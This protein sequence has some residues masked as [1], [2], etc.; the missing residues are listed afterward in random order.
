MSNKR[1]GLKVGDTVASRYVIKGEIGEGGMGTVYKAMPFHDPSQNVA[2]KIIQKLRALG[3][4]DILRFQKEAA[5]MSL[6][7]HPNII[8]F[9]ELGLLNNEYI[10]SSRTGPKSSEID[11]GDG[12]YIVMEIADGK[13]LKNNLRTDSRKDLP[14]FFQVGLQVSSALDYTHGKNI[15]HRDIKPQ[16]IVVGKTW[17]E[18]KGIL[19][20]VLDFG[21]ARLAELT[22]SSASN[23]IRNPEVAGTP[24]YMAPEQTPLMR[25]APVDH[26]VDLYSLGCV[27]YEILTGRPPFV[28]SSREK[29]MARHVKA[30]PEPLRSIRPDVPDIID[31]IVMKLLAKHPDDRYQTAFGLHA[32]LQKA[33]MKLRQQRRVHVSFPLGKNDGFRAVSAQLKLVGRDH[34]FQELIVKYKS[35]SALQGR[36][37]MA[38]IKGE[39]GMGK[40]R[41]LTELRAYLVNGRIRFISTNFSRH[42]TNLPYNALANGFNE[43]LMRLLKGQPHEAEELR[44]KIRTVLGSMAYIVAE[45]IPGLRP[46]IDEEIKHESNV[47]NPEVDQQDLNRLQFQTFAAAF[48][49]FTRCLALDNQPIVFILDDLHWADEK[50]LAL[51]DQ[52]FSHN[53]LQRFYLVASYRP[54]ALK[55]SQRLTDFVNKFKR[56]KRRYI[57]IDLGTLQDD[58]ISELAANMLNSTHSIAPDLITFL[59]ART[60]GNPMYLVELIRTLVAQERINYNSTLGVWEYDINQLKNERIKLDSVDL[61][62]NRIQTY[63]EEDRSVLEVASIIGMTFQYELLL[64]GDNSKGVLARNA[65]QKAIDEGLIS[66]TTDDPDLKH[67]GKSYMFIHPRAREAILDTVVTNRKKQIHKKIALYLLRNVENTE[68]ENILFSIVHHLNEA[69]DQD[70]KI[71]I[72]IAKTGVRY[73]LSAGDRAT[74]KS[75]WAQARRYFEKAEVLVATFDPKRSSNEFINVA[76]RLADIECKLK[77]PQK[78][79]LIYESLLK[80][81]ISRARFA[82]VASKLNSITIYGGKIS[83]SLQMI[84]KGLYKLG[85]PI[86]SQIF[87]KSF[88]AVLRFLRDC[89]PSRNNKGR[90]YRLL[91]K[92]YQTGVDPSMTSEASPHFYGMELYRQAQVIFL[93]ENP[94]IA[95]FYHDQTLQESIRHIASPDTILRSVADRTFLM[96]YFGLARKSYSLIDIALDIARALNLE[97]TQGYIQLYRVLTLDHYRGKYEDFDKKIRRSMKY[98]ETGNDKLHHAYARVFLIH[99][100]LFRGRIKRIERAVNFISGSERSLP[101]RNWLNPRGYAAYIFSLFLNGSHDQLVTEGEKYQRSLAQVNARVNDIFVAVI[102]ILISSVKGEHR[103]SKIYFSRLA[104]NY[105]SKSSILSKESGSYSFLFPFE[106]DFLCFFISVFPDLYLKEHGRYLVNSVNYHEMHVMLKSKVEKPSMMNRTTSKLIIARSSELL[107]N[108]E[109]KHRYGNVIRS[110]SATG[111][112]LI[113]IIAYY[114]FGRY[115]VK[116]GSRNEMNYINKAQKE[117]DLHSFYTLTRLA[118]QT[119]LEFNIPFKPTKVNID[120]PEKEAQMNAILPNLTKECLET[121]VSDILAG[122]FE[123]SIENYISLLEKHYL[124]GGIYVFHCDSN[125]HFNL[126]NETKESTVKIDLLMKYIAPYINLRSA[127][128]LPLSDSPWNLEINQPF[129][130]TDTMNLTHSIRTLTIEDVDT[131]KIIQQTIGSSHET[132]KEHYSENT[133]LNQDAPLGKSQLKHR[134]TSKGQG[135]MNL[136]VPIPLN[137]SNIGIIF[138]EEIHLQEGLNAT[139][140]QDLDYFGSQ[141]G[142]ILASDPKYAHNFQSIKYGEYLLEPSTW[143]DI[144]P[145]GSL[146]KDRDSTWYLGMNL[147]KDDYLL[148]YA[149]FNGALEDRTFISTS[150]WYHLMV[151]RSLIM[152]SERISIS[153]VEIKEEVLKILNSFQ[154]VK[155]VETMSLSF[156]VFNRGSAFA[157]SGHFGPSRPLVLGAENKVTPD[158]H[159]MFNLKNGRAVRYWGVTAELAVGSYYILPHDS[160]KLDSFEKKSIKLSDSRQSNSQELQHMLENQL[161][162]DNIPRYY[163][164]A[165]FKDEEEFEETLPNAK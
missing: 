77:N 158:N 38:V 149:R 66:R 37:H 97:A 5:L 93:K 2:I 142:L 121:L 98:L 72:D 136:I 117:S 32:D 11:V 22:H 80:K 59:R 74:T 140:R 44:R 123:L 29:L 163:V 60:S 132:L 110:A 156:T 39:A 51:V 119:M 111:E 92:A 94:R 18:Q 28:E 89:W 138:V 33:K 161:L 83:H 31:G 164:A 91:Q 41:L 104:R 84:Y 146:R 3:P 162:R 79:A 135:R 102:R 139:S 62:V 116:T 143:L 12:Y 30:N 42:E 165:C 154:R 58:Q 14:F 129:K 26:R 73:N 99:H 34:D 131:T 115:L 7:H 159:I 23:G 113:L 157:Y 19:V 125:D 21:I 112:H 65:L 147:G 64:L 71:A 55:V 25:D 106:D 103:K 85:L 69:L 76:E 48:S 20:K 1:L 148:T 141:L 95:F 68:K 10:D 45:K 145:H 118:E 87:L 88:P 122:N 109:I 134:S 6:L 49:D 35:V 24:I 53:N 50:S 107:S 81:P 54:S 127:L 137:N 4:D 120:T 52:F 151:L 36:S 114:W 155:E 108:K 150:L 153:I 46:F 78:G 133:D 56:L 96:G 57:E 160:S 86:P 67:L 63:T 15:I 144:W 101:Y 40:T 70:E 27:L 61:T 82:K 16:N 100:D 47:S 43:Y 124:N 90:L 105:L 17:Q 130:T 13:D 126:V 8:C 152:A 128:F 75:S 9:H